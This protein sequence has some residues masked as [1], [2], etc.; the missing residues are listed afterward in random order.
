MEERL[1]SSAETV[2]L[3]REEFERR[4]TM[5]LLGV[6]VGMASAEDTILAK[7]EWSK[8]SGSSERQRRDVAGIVATLGESLDLVYLGRWLRALDLES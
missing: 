6:D 4:S 8:A 3:S 2:P 7:L 1:S 5:S